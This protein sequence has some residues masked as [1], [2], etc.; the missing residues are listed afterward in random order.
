MPSR[1]PS[2]SPTSFGQGYANLTSLPLLHGVFVWASLIVPA[3]RS[4]AAGAPWFA[5]Y[6]AVSW[7]IW[8]YLVHRD[9]AWFVRSFFVSFCLFVAAPSLV[10]RRG[11]PTAHSA[12]SAAF[13]PA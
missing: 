11:G 10:S 1:N 3:S 2:S 8:P 5:V 6:L 9:Q 4:P 12:R 7:L 13:C